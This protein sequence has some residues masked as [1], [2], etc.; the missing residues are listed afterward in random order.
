MGTLLPRPARR[1]SGRVALALATLLAA[2][3][4]LVGAGAAGAQEEATVRSTITVTKEVEG[5]APTDAGGEPAAFRFIVGCGQ[6]EPTTLPEL[7]VEMSWSWMESFTLAGGSATITVP[8]DEDCWVEETDPLGAEMTTWRLGDGEDTAD[9]RTGLLQVPPGDAATVTFTNTFAELPPAPAIALT[10]TA[11]DAT[12]PSSREDGRLV[13]D[14]TGLDGAG[15]T[16]EYVI[17]NV[18]DETLIDLTLVD[19]RT[20]DLSVDLAGVEL[21]IGAE[22]TVTATYDV[23]PEEV[24]A[25]LVTS[26][27]TVA[28]VGSGSAAP[29]DA[30]DEA[31]VFLVSVEGVALTP[32]LETE[33]DAEQASTSGTEVLG[34]QLPQTGVDAILIS[35]GGVLLALLGVGVV[36]AGRRGQRTRVR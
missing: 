10:M 19:D 33:P 4:V 22:V 9:L 27:A 25:G 24:A 3:A 5:P 13:L 29:V 34:T 21:G 6:A 23:A 8:A 15:V 30:S 26:R 35:L 36:L 12:A 18:G 28:G 32:P 17:A 2:Q 14:L 11:I 1:R 16:Y 7:D 20:G 31:T